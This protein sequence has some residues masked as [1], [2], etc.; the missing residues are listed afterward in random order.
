MIFMVLGAPGCGKGT[1]AR[2][3]AKKYNLQHISTGDLL[4][5]ECELKTPIGLEIEKI[6]AQGQWA[7]TSLVQTVL[8]RE[9]EKFPQGGFVLDGWPRY[10]EQKEIL[11]E[12]LSGRGLRLNLVFYLEL[13][14][15]EALKRIRGRAQAS[16][17]T[18]S[19]RADDDESVAKDRLDLYFRYVGEVLEYYRQKDVLRVIDDRPPIDQV[20]ARIEKAIDDYL[21]N[22]SGN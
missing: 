21:K 8:L 1:Q 19:R 11:D 10:P 15:E 18:G 3:I 16:G 2:L 6:L 17:P 9:L 22:R 5:R 20:F 4:R 14:A 12:F 7:P 13:T